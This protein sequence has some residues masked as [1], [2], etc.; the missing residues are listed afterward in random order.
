M[1]TNA[2]GRSALWGVRHPIPELHVPPDLWHL[3]SFSVP[4]QQQSNW[5]WAAVGCGVAHYYE[6]DSTW[7]QCEIVNV[8][9]KAIHSLDLECC[10]PEGSQMP[11]NGQ[12]GVDQSLSHTN[13]WAGN[14][15]V[16]DFGTVGQQI[17]M[18]RPIAV[19]IAWSGGG[20]HIVAIGGY[21]TIETITGFLEYVH[22]EDPA[23]GP[24]DIGYDE[25]VS[26]YQGAGT[27]VASA[28]TKP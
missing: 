2:S 24:S 10:G 25:L 21:R 19:W 9:F 3:L 12:S 6:P 18:G 17:K 4:L 5:C 16:A 28:W 11:C 7:T 13:H 23:Y 27:W 8:V 14:G 1:D 22:V 15:P 20:G 26:N